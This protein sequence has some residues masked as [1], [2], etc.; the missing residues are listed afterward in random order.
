MQLQHDGTFLYPRKAHSTPRIPT[1][2]QYLNTVASKFHLG[3]SG[4]WTD[5]HL[6]FS[7]FN[8]RHELK[9]VIQRCANG[10]CASWCGKS[11]DNGY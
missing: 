8:E 9:V 7:V 3:T 4:G 5:V 10:T 2:I 1:V 6:R 11:T